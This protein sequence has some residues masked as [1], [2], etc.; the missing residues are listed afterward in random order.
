L[1]GVAE[2]GPSHC[3]TIN[4]EFLKFDKIMHSPRKNH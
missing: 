2:D 1:Q 4:F 3:N